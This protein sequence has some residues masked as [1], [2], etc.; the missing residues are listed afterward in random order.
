MT[1]GI[2]TLTGGILLGLTSLTDGSATLSSG[3]LEAHKITDGIATL[4]GGTLTV[5]KIEFD[6]GSITTSGNMKLDIDTTVHCVGIIDGTA[7][8]TGGT[9][10]NALRV[11]ATT[12][13]CRTYRWYVIECG[14]S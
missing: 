13:T 1:D 11:E 14:T 2:A 7:T 4:S 8:L 10:S 12:L 9:L 6:N 5:D 3:T